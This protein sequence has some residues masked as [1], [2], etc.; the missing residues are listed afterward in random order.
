VIPIVVILTLKSSPAP[1]GFRRLF[2]S[3]R[4]SYPSGNGVMLEV[5]MRIT[6]FA[7]LTNFDARI[8]V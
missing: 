6:L 1:R 5:T 4:V 2:V 3:S 8:A 7:S